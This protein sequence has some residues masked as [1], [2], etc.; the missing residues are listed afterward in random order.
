M[1]ARAGYTRPLDNTD[2]PS[3]LYDAWESSLGSNA[4]NQ[5]SLENV[6]LGIKFNRAPMW[7][8]DVSQAFD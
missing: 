8:E 2:V 4:V 5:K 3:I 7:R 1:L 6:G